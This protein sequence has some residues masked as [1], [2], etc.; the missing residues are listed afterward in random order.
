M[1]TLINFFRRDGTVLDVFVLMKWNM[2][3]DHIVI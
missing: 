2:N 1:P 3:Y